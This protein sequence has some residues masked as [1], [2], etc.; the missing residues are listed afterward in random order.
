MIDKQGS[1]V[2]NPDQQ[3]QN[4][5]NESDQM[6]KGCTQVQ[7]VNSCSG[8][9]QHKVKIPSLYLHFFFDGTGN[10]KH[11]TKVRLDQLQDQDYLA[12]R[13]GTIFLVLYKNC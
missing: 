1:Y 13:K 5:N 11:N 10:N 2:I 9:N 12:I 7:N 8:N 4:E 6:P 3:S